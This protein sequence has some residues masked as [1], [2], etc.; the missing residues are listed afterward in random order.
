MPDHSPLAAAPPAQRSIHYRRR[1]AYALWV[2]LLLLSAWPLVL[3]ERPPVLA[4]ASLVVKVQIRNA[5]PGAQV[6]AWAGPRSRWTGPALF[7]ASPIQVPLDPDGAAT[8]PVFRL[9]IAR[10]RWVKDYI[11]RDTWD[12]MMLEFSAP[13]QALRYFPLP[14]AQDIRSGTLRPHW[15]LTTTLGLS[16]ASLQAEAKP[17]DEAP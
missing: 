14:L 2:A 8:L 7:A 12:L 11:P 1:W 6:K 10:R 13:G 17:P 4:S 16:W 9:P 15:K 5:P 3:W